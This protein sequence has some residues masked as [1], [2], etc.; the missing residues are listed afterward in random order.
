MG[1]PLS[2]LGGLFTGGASLA[3][4]F[5]QNEYNSAQAQENRDF[6]ERMS[7]TSYQR[8]MADMRA[9]GLNPILAAAK[10]GASTP[11]GATAAPSANILGEAA[12]RSATTALS[13]RRLESDIEQQKAQTAQTYENVGRTAQESGLLAAKQK[14]EA[15]ETE[16]VKQETASAKEM[17]GYRAGESAEGRVRAGHFAPNS[18]GALN[19][20]A[21]KYA[22]TANKMLSGVGSV[23]GP[24]WL[25]RSVGGA[26]TSSAKSS[27]KFNDVVRGGNDFG[28]RWGDWGRPGM[29]DRVSDRLPY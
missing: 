12:E 11:G 5:M 9:A 20:G 18:A 17:A 10:G 1:D 19:Y 28:S 7:D 23:V 25:A 24:A 16:R 26:L 29:V 22:D 27:G 6:Q 4:G 14:T 13:T 8:Q 3:G 15:A 21:G 2:L